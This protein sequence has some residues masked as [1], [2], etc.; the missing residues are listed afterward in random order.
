MSSEVERIYKRLALTA[1]LREPGAFR[2]LEVAGIPILI[3]RD[4][5]GGIGAFVSMC[6]HRGNCVVHDEPGTARSFRCGRAGPR[7]A[8][9]GSSRSAPPSSARCL[10]E[11][12]AWR[13][14]AR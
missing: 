13:A 2:T 8:G 14:A 5:D 10:V 11:P 12:I 3:G 6:S 1:E 4:Q 9:R 7:A